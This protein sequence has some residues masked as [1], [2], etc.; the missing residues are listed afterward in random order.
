[1]Q[2]ELLALNAVARCMD[3]IREGSCPGRND[4]L[5]MV[6]ANLTAAEAGAEALLQVAPASALPCGAPRQRGA[7][8]AAGGGYCAPVGL[9]S[10]SAMFEQSLGAVVQVGRGALEGL[11]VSVLIKLFLEP[12]A[13]AEQGGW[14][15][16]WVWVGGCVW[17]RWAAELGCTHRQPQAALLARR[18]PK[19]ASLRGVCLLHG[20][21]FPPFVDAQA[22]AIEGPVCLVAQ[23][24]HV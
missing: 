13:P 22:R 12:L 5:V 14:A 16:V 2:Q 9:A 11:N 23:C 4:L 19:A 3:Y 15:L 18:L 10:H 21:D 7:I 8:S 1:M 6:L 20:A 17:G 24:R